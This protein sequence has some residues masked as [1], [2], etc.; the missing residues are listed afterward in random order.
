MT[1]ETRSQFYLTVA[2][3]MVN[4]KCYPS[5]KDCKN[6]ADAIVQKY[7]FLKPSVGTPTGAIIQ[8]LV[9]C[10]KELRRKKATN[11]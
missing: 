4:Y 9:N 3:S 2:S 7:A 11:I 8:S 6:V 5:A 1:K 10:F